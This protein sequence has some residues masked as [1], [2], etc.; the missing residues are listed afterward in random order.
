MTNEFAWN[1]TGLKFAV[2]MTCEGFDMAEND[3][4]ITVTR[5]MKKMEFD[6]SNAIVDG[7]GQWYIC[8]TSEV[9]GPGLIYII[10]DAIV[11]DSDFEA[12]VRHEIQKYELI[13]N[14]GL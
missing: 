14:K 7:N 8:I 13:Y 6:K 3:W 12:G 2:N 11:P 10:F 4:T 5:G 9:L 1:G